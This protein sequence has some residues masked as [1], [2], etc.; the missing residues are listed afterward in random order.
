MF[1]HQMCPNC[2][3]RLSAQGT[4]TRVIEDLSGSHVLCAKEYRCTGEACK[5]YFR[6]WNKNLV[7]K[8]PDHIRPHFDC[9]V[10][11][12]LSITRRVVNMVLHLS[13]SG[14]GFQRIADCLNDIRNIELDQKAYAYMAGEIADLSQPTL[15]SRGD[16]KIIPMRSKPRAIFSGR[17]L[18][19]LLM[20]IRGKEMRDNGERSMQELG[21][22]SHFAADESM[23][24]NKKTKCPK[25]S[26]SMV[27]RSVTSIM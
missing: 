26:K 23:K 10:T 20:S 21:K 18:A 4:I 9:H 15:L 5:K 12:G 27:A 6:G 24:N 7:A 25:G 11:K 1:T 8:L 13:T 19:E 2:G 3:S 14:V 16:K 22:G 17:Q